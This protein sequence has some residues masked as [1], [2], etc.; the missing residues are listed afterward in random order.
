MP[1]SRERMMT[2]GKVKG[3]IAMAVALAAL[4]LGSEEVDLNLPEGFEVHRIYT[5]PVKA[6]GSW[7]CIAFDPRGRLI[8]SSQ[9]GGLHRLTLP[10]LQEDRPPLVETMDVDVGAAQGLLWAFDSLYVV[11]NGT[12]KSGRKSGLYRVRDSNGDDRLDEVS[13]LRRF[14]GAGEHGPHGLALTP[15][16]KGIFVLAGNATEIPEPLDD[17]R[18][19][20]IWADDHILP[21]EQYRDSIMGPQGAWVCI[22]DPDGRNWELFCRGMRNPYDIALDRGGNLFTWDSDNERDTGQPWYRPT[23]VCF[24]SSGGDY[25]WRSG[26]GKWPKYYKDS[27]PPAVETGTGSPTGIVFGYGTHFPAKYRD[28]LFVLDWSFGSIEAVFLEPDGAG[29]TGRSEGFASGSALPVTDVAVG[30]DGALYFT[31]GGRGL[32]S[33]LYRIRHRSPDFVEV[34]DEEPPANKLAAIKRELDSHHVSR[35]PAHIDKAWPHLGIE[36]RFVAASAR[37]ILEHHGPDLWRERVFEESDPMAKINGLIA[38]ARAGRKGDQ[39]PIL[40]ALNRMEAESLH[41]QGVLD[42]LR[43]YQLNFTRF[44]RASGELAR[45]TVN[46]LEKLYPSDTFFINRELSRLLVYLESPRVIATSL[47]LL[48]KGRTQEEQIHFALVLRLVKTGWT[49]D[50]RKTYLRWFNHAATSYRGGAGVV[51]EP[52]KSERIFKQV[53]GQIRSAAIST[54][55]PG[56][57]T[58]LKEILHGGD[59]AFK[60]KLVKPAAGGEV[61]RRWKV[62]DFVEALDGLKGRNFMRGRSMYTAASCAACHQFAGEGQPI[63]PNLS[64]VVA[65]FNHRALLESIIE[66]SKV[67]SDQFQQSLV[68][69]RDGSTLTGT[70]LD[71]RDGH[72][73]LQLNPF[74]P[75]SILP[76]D[77]TRIE[78]LSPSPVSSM[79]DSLLDTLNWNEVMDLMA[80]LL[81][82]GNPD[83]A[84]FQ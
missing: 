28:A 34:A 75:D 22:T 9:Y 8:A 26:S 55:T 78:R 16:G 6:Q 38:L 14:N 47:D 83:D 67:I 59:A 39:E 70:I 10:P 48:T 17:S 25:G 68:E 2:L 66:P 58:A 1:K 18:V 35:D 42:L 24:L 32:D 11:V 81:S 3:W 15:D 31:T 62:T 44:G 13:L 30:Q 76:I 54:L 19:P 21:R 33:F 82:R 50:Q 60:P 84:V 56:E 29:F 77:S 20:K 12:P 51:N 74:V 72:L 45:A 41:E 49:L 64:A 69:L 61:V 79:P 73:K 40:H 5:V 4:N 65:R 63:G 80:Y 57:R 52:S 71:N 7:V 37:T 53:F 36:D 46:R 43:A 23:R 27:L